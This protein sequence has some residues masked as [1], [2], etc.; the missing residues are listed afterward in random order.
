[1]SGTNVWLKLKRSDKYSPEPYLLDTNHDVWHI[2]YT[3]ALNHTVE[4]IMQ[5]CI[6][7]RKD[8]KRLHELIGKVI[9]KLHPEEGEITEPWFFPE[10]MSLGEFIKKSK[11]VFIGLH[12]GIGENGTLQKMLEK[13]KVP[14]N[15]SGSRASELCMDKYKTGEAIRP[16][17]KEGIHSALK[18]IENLKKFEKMQSVDYRRYWKDLIYEMGSPTI[19]VKPIDDGCS[20]GIARLYGPRDLEIYISFAAKHAP[21]IPQGLLKE[22]HGIIEMPSNPMKHV[23]FEQFITTDKVRVIKNELKWQTR[24]DWIEITIGVLEKN[25]VLSAMQPSITVAVGNVLSLEEKFQGGTGVNITPP[26][27]PY[28]KPS[29]VQKAMKRME[30]VAKVLGIKGYARIDAFMHTKTGELIIIEANTVP[31]LTPSTVI[32]HQALAEKPPLY[33]VEFLEKIISNSY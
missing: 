27:G 16:L 31:G 13:A 5:S 19:I 18:K 14:F 6:N 25:G 33:P 26:P 11:Y 3:L 2:P 24:G 9:K 23:M 20:A 8:E 21:N 32:Y 1:M 22:Q 10:K 30:K 7:A 15:G 17:K 29:A 4:E 28:V 12:G